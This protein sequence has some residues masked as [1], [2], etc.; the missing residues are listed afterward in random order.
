MVLKMQIFK[1]PFVKS[2]VISLLCT[3][4]VNLYASN[5][6]A[7]YN[8][9][10]Y[11]KINPIGTDAI[12]FFGWFINDSDPNE[13]QSAFQII[14]SSSISKLNSNIGDIWD[15][16]KVISRK[17]NYVYFNGKE[18]N[19]GTQYYWKVRTWDKD[20]NVSSYSSMAT[21]STGLFSNTDWSGANWI[22][23]ETKDQDDYTYYRKHFSVPNKKIKR[24]IVY[25]T[26]CH[27]YE[28]YI[29]GKFIG[30]GF[31]HHY[32]Q[33]SYYQAWDITPFLL[34][35]NEN[36]LGC[37]THWYG[38]GQG[39][40]KG[41]RGLLA[42]TIIDYDDSTSTTIV[43]D[44][45]WKQNRAEQWTPNRPL[46]NGE[47]I[48]RIELI[49]SRKKIKDWNKIS[50]DDTNWNQ[51]TEIGTHP[52]APW[53]GVLRPDLTR[54]I[55]KEIKPKTVTN[56]KNS[57][58]I[59]DL[60][61]IYAGNFKIKFEGGVAGDTIK[62]L[63]GFVLNEDG[64]VSKEINQNTKLDS[65]F[66]TNGER[67]IYNP[68]VYLGLRYLQVDNS[69]NKLSIDNVGFITRHYELNKDDVFESSDTTLNQ[70]W[71]LMVHSLMVGAQ[72]GFVDTPTREKGT[73]LGD[74]WAQGVPCMSVLY[75]RTMNLKS[76]NEFLDSQDQYWPDGRLNAVY[77]NVDGGRDIPDFTQVYL[78]WAWDYYMQTGNI[79][80]LRS[81][82][83]QLKKIAEYVNSYQN[84]TTGLIQNLKGGKNQ[85]EYGII[86][87]PQDMRY[88]YDM[89]TSSRTVINAYA[90]EDFKI[91]SNIADVLDYDDD[92]DEYM[93]KAENIKKA[94]NTY[95]LNE[96]G[97]YIDGLYSDN[98]PSN[99]ISQHAN[100]LPFSFGIASD[101]KT[102]QIIEEIKQR[103]MSVGMVC[104]RWLPEALGKADEGEQLYNLYTNTNWDGW[105]NTLS[106]GATVT[107][108]SW[109]ALENNESLS[110]PWGAVGLLAIQNYFLGIKV[111]SPQA[112]TVQIKPLDFGTKLKYAKGTYKTDKGDIYLDWKKSDDNYTL[113]VKVPVNI[114]AKVYIP[115]GAN[116]T[117]WVT[118]NNKKT[119]GTREGDYIYLG[120]IGS[121]E[122]LIER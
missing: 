4:S 32:P 118:I 29:N 47:G 43:S 81:N 94:M 116:N 30:K 59:I 50:F 86:D 60:G 107:W 15:S 10:C 74:S 70:V 48:G 108:E 103:N 13:I 3:L 88:G 91:I 16:K 110:H 114:T 77:P 40:A 66:I 27:S 12:P 25:I 99:H 34:K 8:L 37:L 87:W 98:N 58:Y 61:K 9:R 46:R 71:S 57:K 113:S 2:I 54:L 76:L 104:L 119:K 92:K 90:Y 5:P 21:F 109:N 38:G 6:D 67:A 82:Y 26:A 72:E 52:T 62:M 14:V 115:A 33:Y 49:D 28:L 84:K 101:K 31:N 1:T 42:K 80:F 56:L 35:N 41:T 120:S 55:E 63:G 23:R 106:K 20:D 64:T 78:I 36:L 122:H 121:G 79:E 11:D 112:D 73:F 68:N 83:T 39:R 111:L 69:P 65:Y 89:K 45:S 22:K 117:N 51:A 93:T 85:Y 105:A 53:T 19:S 24:A 95:F 100:A 44:D 17:Q 96:N 102:K 18:L 75:D 97:V 7:P